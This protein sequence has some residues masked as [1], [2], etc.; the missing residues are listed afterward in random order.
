MNPIAVQA[1]GLTVS[2]GSITALDV[3]D[4]SIPVGTTTAIIGPNGSGKSTFLRAAAGLVAPLRGRIEVPAR[5][6]PGA[7]A[8]VLQS[9]ELDPALPLTVGE[10]VRMARYPRLGLAR[11]FGARDRDAVEGAI[12]RLELD[13]LTGRQLGDLSGGQRQ[14]VLVAQGLAQQSELLLMDEPLTGL[15]LASRER[16]WSIVAAERSAGRTVIVSTHDLGDARR[17][18][19]VMLVATTLVAF[20]PPDEVLS[21]SVLRAAYG[22]RLIEVEE[23]SMLLDDPH[24]GH[25]H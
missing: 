15:D 1:D 2:Y 16:I 19:L 8:L 18:D 11:R 6:A 9:T 3:V 12:D 23:G 22:A 13:A 5:R 10:A 17:C 21:P 4:V 7:V 20:G 25:E 14:R 24:H